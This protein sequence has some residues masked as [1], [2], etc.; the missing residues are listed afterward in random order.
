MLNSFSSVQHICLNISLNSKKIQVWKTS[1]ETQLELKL[2]PL[3]TA[4]SW[5]VVCKPHANCFQWSCMPFDANISLPHA[6]ANC[7]PTL[8][9][10]QV[11]WACSENMCKSMKTPLTPYAILAS[12]HSTSCEKNCAH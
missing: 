6:H 12:I 7:S 10:C 4:T 2:L 11:F 3:M 1:V 9:F 5:K 8:N